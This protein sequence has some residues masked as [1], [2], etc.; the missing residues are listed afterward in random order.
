MLFE[1]RSELAQLQPPREPLGAISRMLERALS[2]RDAVAAQDATTQLVRVNRE[3]LLK[4]IEAQRAGFKN[5]TT[6]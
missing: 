2:E 1:R 5:A 3:H 4:S 6:R